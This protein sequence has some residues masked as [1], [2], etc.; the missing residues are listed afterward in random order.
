MGTLIIILQLILSLSILVTLH[1]FGHYWPAKKFGMRVE[2]FFLFFDPWFN[3]FSVQKGETEYG[4]GW[5]PLGGYVKIA[6]MVDESMD[7]E[8]LAMEPQPWEFRSKPAWQRLIVMIG[9]VTVNFILG[10]LLF[11]MVL[12]VWGEKYL[13]NDK[14]IHGL[15]PSVLA[16][17]MGFQPGDRVIQVGDQP[18]NEFNPGKVITAMLF[19]NVQDVRILRDGKEVSLQVPDSLIVQLPSQRRSPLFVP[20]VPFVVGQLVAGAAADKSGLI[21]VGD[22]IVS[23]NGQATPYFDDFAKACSELKD[24]AVVLSLFRDGQ[25]IDV[26]VTTNEN[27]KLGIGPYAPDYFYSYDRRYYGLLESIPLGVQKGYDFLATQILAF[28]QMF[29]GRIKASESLGGFVSIAKL[30]PSKWDWE[31]FWRMTAILSLILGFMNLLPIPA[32]DG[33]HV[34]FLLY[35]MIARKPV[36]QRTLEVAQ[37]AGFVILMSLLIYA[38][39]LDIYR[40]FQ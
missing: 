22:S 12:F 20:R 3:L 1:E 38:N 32:L 4:I 39:G 27:G 2:K 21:E 24:Q 37:V 31:H 6:G 16:T 10:F 14:V 26:E 36:S 40:L 11:G 30:F 28:G 29:N 5:L 15:S 35:E 25:Q 17:K 34:I 9:G 23:L 33:G 13:D 8:Q 19:H 18:I 7:K